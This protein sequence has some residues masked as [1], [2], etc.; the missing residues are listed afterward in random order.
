MAR[1]VFVDAVLNGVFV[2]QAA[3]GVLALPVR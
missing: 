2:V 1:M 3:R